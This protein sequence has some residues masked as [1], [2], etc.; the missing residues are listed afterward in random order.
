MPKDKRTTAERRWYRQRYY[1][2]NKERIIAQARARYFRLTGDLEK[3]KELEELLAKQKMAL[4]AS[5][6]RILPGNP[7]EL[8]VF[9]LS[10][11]L[12]RDTSPTKTPTT[13]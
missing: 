6:Q 10:D 1:E 7:D 11:P 8:R 13:S 9:S 5:K 3:V 4:L 2:Q 12:I